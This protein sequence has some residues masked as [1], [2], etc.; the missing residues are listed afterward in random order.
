MS[1][2]RISLLVAFVHRRKVL[3]AWWLTFIS[4]FEQMYVISLQEQL[5]K[6]PAENV[7]IMYQYRLLQRKL[8]TSKIKRKNSAP[9]RINVKYEPYMWSLPATEH[10]KLN[11]PYSLRIILTNSRRLNTWISVCSGNFSSG[12]SMK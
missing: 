3:L 5:E 6:S 4:S 7:L 12:I 8:V 10:L 2:F 11:D 1:E 9:V